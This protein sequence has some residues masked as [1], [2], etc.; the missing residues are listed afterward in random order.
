MWQTWGCIVLF[1]FPFFFCS[2]HLA[3]L[4]VWIFFL[5]LVPFFL[6]VCLCVCARVRV[7][8]R[9]RVCVRA[10]ACVCARVCARVCVCVWHLIPVI[11]HVC[12]PALSATIGEDMTP[13]EHRTHV[14]PWLRCT[15]IGRPFSPGPGLTAESHSRQPHKT[16]R[17]TITLTD[18]VSEQ[19]HSQKGI[20]QQ[21][22][23]QL[24]PRKWSFCL[25]IL[26]QHNNVNFTKVCMVAPWKSSRYSKTSTR[27]RRRRCCCCWWCYFY[28]SRYKLIF[29][30]N[31]PPSGQNFNNDFIS[32]S[33][34]LLS[35]VLV[36]L[37]LKPGLS[38]VLCASEICD[39]S[40]CLQRHPP[41]DQACQLHWP[42][43]RRKE[44]HCS[45]K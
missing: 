11:C 15:P 21:T 19:Y 14:L 8:V 37:P 30:P 10:R 42:E 40:L 4:R 45:W 31:L 18:N 28:C 41:G 5:F 44:F 22:A 43:P 25:T 13:N 17:N 26:A 27:C 34:L 12:F 32:C 7:W 39:P 1:C 29:P 6:F 33:S 23:S 20:I 2:L 38:F 16:Q 3:Q 35:R 36:Y 9:V 24:D